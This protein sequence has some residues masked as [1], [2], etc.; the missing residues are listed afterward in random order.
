MQVRIFVQFCASASAECHTLASP[1][2]RPAA[3]RCVPAVAGVLSHGKANVRW[4]DDARQ[5]FM[6]RSCPTT[7]KQ[8]PHD[9]LDGASF[10]RKMAHAPVPLRCE[11]YWGL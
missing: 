5:I 7:L 3:K 9:P 4:D 11:E 8:S 6:Q 1:E 2:G 10:K